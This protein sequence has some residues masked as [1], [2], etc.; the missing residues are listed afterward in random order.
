[1]QI[2]VVALPALTQMLLKRVASIP[3]VEIRETVMSL[4][5]AKGFWL[6]DNITLARPQVLV[7]G[8][9][10]AHIHPDGSL[11]ASLPP[12]LALEA[13]N[14]GWAIRHPWA[15]QKPGWDGFV[16]IYT[17]GSTEALDVVLTLVLESYNFVTGRKI[18]VASE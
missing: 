13:V 8:R 15:H 17:P 18:T 16:M 4:A 2:G 3:D 6:S 5:G 1:M 7:R 14:T 12:Q 9:E 11:H 10:F